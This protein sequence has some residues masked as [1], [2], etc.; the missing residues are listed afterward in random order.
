MVADFLTISNPNFSVKNKWQ[1]CYLFLNIAFFY[2]T[3]K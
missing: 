2:K 3:I 1:Y